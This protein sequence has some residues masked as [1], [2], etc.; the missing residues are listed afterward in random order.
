VKTHLC[1]DIVALEAQICTAGPPDFP[2]L[3]TL[4]HNLCG[5]TFPR[6]FKLHKQRANQQIYFTSVAQ[7]LYT[8]SPTTFFP[9]Q[10]RLPC[11]N[12][13]LALSILDRRSLKAS[14]LSTGAAHPPQRVVL[15]CVSTK[16]I[17]ALA[18]RRAVHGDHSAGRELDAVGQAG[19]C[20]PTRRCSG[21][22]TTVRTFGTIRVRWLRGRAFSVPARGRRGLSFMRPASTL[23]ISR[24]RRS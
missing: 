23:M 1:S 2:L 6:S 8:S 11:P 18:D 10:L 15:A 5:S 22:S 20:R 13:R 7:I 4:A 12:V 3:F 21:C 14:S 24:Y 16:D 9:I 17:G 19:S